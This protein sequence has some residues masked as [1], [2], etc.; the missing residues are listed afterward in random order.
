MKVYLLFIALF[1]SAQLGWSQT[2][3]KDGTHRNFEVTTQKEAHYEGGDEAL[4]RKMF[5]LMEYPEAAR[6]QK[7]EG[8]ITVAF[9]VE[10]D[11]S[12]SEIRAM[13]DLGHG[14]KAE[15]ERIIGELEFVPAVQNGKQVRQQMML[16]VLF[17]IYEQDAD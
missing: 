5:Q 7:I 9:F 1:L 15:A 8:N 10:E 11:G 2:E 6:E 14:T 16:P 13:N 12:T 3:I 4:Y 17:R